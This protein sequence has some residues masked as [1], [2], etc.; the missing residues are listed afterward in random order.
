MKI[1]SIIN[2]AIILCITLFLSAC[3]DKGKDNNTLLLLLF[4]DPRS[5]GD[6]KTFAADGISFKMVY[7]P[8]GMTFPTGTDDSGIAIV[9]KAFWIGE[10][11]V[12]YQLWDKVRTWAVTHGYT[13]INTGTMGDGTGDTNQHP[14]TTINWRESM[15]WC[16]A[17][18]EWYNEQKNTRYSC[19]YYSDSGYTTPIR[20]VVDNASAVYP[21]PGGQDD[22]YVKANATGFRLP[23]S[24]EWE[25]A[26][27]YV[28]DANHDGDILDPGEYYH[29]DHVSGD[30][31]S[32]CYPVDSGTSTVFGKYAVY[33][34]NSGTSTAPVKSSLP[35]A[36]G[37]YD[38]SGSEQEWCFDW[39]PSYIG[40]GRIRRGG[41]WYNNSEPLQIGL[42]FGDNPAYEDPVIGF[43]LAMNR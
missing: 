10:T 17:L 20:T 14:V 22:P 12:T 1:Q 6:Q 43:R 27:R 31:T 39:H 42:T 23:L 4:T 41:G 36:L 21:D 26:A 40:T 30:T 29:G 9:K 32:Y 35:N 34:D 28:G 38:M 19:T 8:G 16:N 2:A 18:T 13:F 3:Q 37:I 24:N 11:E 7:V 15:V 5:A 25:F 33:K